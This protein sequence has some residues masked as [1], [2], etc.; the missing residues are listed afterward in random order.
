MLLPGYAWVFSKNVSPLRP[1]VWPAIA[2]IQTNVYELEE[3]YYI[4]LV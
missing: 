2:N 1:A 3:H 4:N